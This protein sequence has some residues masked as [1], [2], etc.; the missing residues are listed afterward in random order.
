MSTATSVK[1]LLILEIDQWFGQDIHSQQRLS[2]AIISSFWR[3]KAKMSP[4][5]ELLITECK[6]AQDQIQND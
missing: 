3:S 2:N 6:P 5:S 4:D 1:L